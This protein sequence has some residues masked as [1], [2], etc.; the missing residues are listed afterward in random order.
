MDILE[1]VLYAENMS[2][3][4]VEWTLAA[5]ASMA[6]DLIYWL[7]TTHDAVRE[8][9]QSRHQRVEQLREALHELRHTMVENA[10]PSSAADQECWQK[11]RYTPIL[12]LPLAPEC[13]KQPKTCDEDA[14]DSDAQSTAS[15]DISERGSSLG[16]IDSIS[17]YGS[18]AP[19]RQATIDSKSA[20]D[21]SS[22]IDFERIEMGLEKR[23]TC[24][25]RN[26]P[27]KLTEDGLLEAIKAVTGGRL[28]KSSVE[29]VKLP[30][31]RNGKG[32]GFAFVQFKSPADVGVFAMGFH[33]YCWPT[34][35][36]CKVSEVV[37]AK[38]Q[39]L[40]AAS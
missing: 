14:A 31:C 8:I 4:Y 27:G 34:L 19:S 24:L 21:G 16:S 5:E 36:S 20:V 35:Y 10:P 39:D 17:S 3:R 13:A 2:A 40:S 6:L 15:G 1:T 28:D 29:R 11:L 30:M 12:R 37:Y 7:S 33:K 25:I 32:I 38:V 26:L 18:F 9:M 22:A 23:T